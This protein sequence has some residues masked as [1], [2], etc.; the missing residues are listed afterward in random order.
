MERIEIVDVCQKYT[1]NRG[2]LFTALNHVS[3]TWTAGESVA[4]MGESGSGKSTLAR[5]LIGLEKPS[6]GQIRFDGKDTAKWSFQKWRE[7]RTELQAVFQDAG[8]TLSPGRSVLQNAEEA[9]CNLTILTKQQRLERIT[10]LMELMELSTKLFDTPACRLS[11]GEQRRVGLLRALA[12]L[13]KFLV[14]DEVTA[15]LDLITTE[16]V[17]RVLENYQKEYS[18]NYLIVTHDVGTASRLCTKLY[19]FEHGRIIHQSVRK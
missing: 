14:L 9:L 10:A 3:L 1:D 7:R 4:V 8:G 2:E 15:G 19:Q 13:P 11:G 18:C 12:V 5:L 6:S 16:A 17:L